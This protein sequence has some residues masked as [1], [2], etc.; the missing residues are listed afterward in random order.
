MELVEHGIG[1]DTQ[2]L[3][4]ILRATLIHTFFL[5]KFLKNG[6]GV[7]DIQVTQKSESI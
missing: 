2:E 6:N 7:K 4:V 3:G 5:M 1:T